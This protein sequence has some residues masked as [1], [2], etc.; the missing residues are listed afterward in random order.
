[1]ETEVLV[2]RDEKIGGKLGYWIAS[3]EG[4][5]S[6]QNTA[7]VKITICLTPLDNVNRETG[8]TEP[9]VLG[10]ESTDIDIT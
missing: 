1:M 4:V 2:G 9:V 5:R 10:S 7:K 6:N 8:A 3:A